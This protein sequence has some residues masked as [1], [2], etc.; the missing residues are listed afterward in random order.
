MS[1]NELVPKSAADEIRSV[2]APTIRSMMPDSKRTS[3]IA[4]SGISIERFAIQPWRWITRSLVT[5]KFDV[6]HHVTRGIGYRSIATIQIAGQSHQGPPSQLVRNPTA[7][8][9]T[10]VYRAGS[11]S[12]IGCGRRSRTRFSPSINRRRGN[13]MAGRYRGTRGPAIRSGRG[14]EVLDVAE[15]DARLAGVGGQLERTEVVDADG[16]ARRLLAVERPRAHH[17]ADRRGHR[18]PFVANA[19]GQRR[20]GRPVD[21]GEPL[22]E[23]DQQL[24]LAGAV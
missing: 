15:R 1:S 17:L 19:L 24:A 7:T 22:E 16:A 4:S 9:S 10:I 3:L 18:Q 23:R 12:A 20:V 2:P 14:T 5:T 21:R 6:S 8:V 13:G 11:A